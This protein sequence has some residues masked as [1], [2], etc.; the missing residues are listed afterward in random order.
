MTCIL[1]NLQEA[2]PLPPLSFYDAESF[3]VDQLG[4]D[5]TAGSKA[6]RAMKKNESPIRVREKEPEALKGIFWL[7]NQGDSSSV[8]SFAKTDE[9]GGVSPG[10]LQTGDIAYRIRVSGDQSWAFADNGPND[11]YNLAQLADLVYNFELLDGTLDAPT[12]F[13]IIPSLQ[14]P[15][16]C[17][18]LELKECFIKEGLLDFS[19]TLTHGAGLPDHPVYEESVV[20]RRDSTLFGNS[21]SYEAV[22]IIDGDGYRIEPAWSMWVSY[23]Q[24][25]EAGDTPGVNHYRRLAEKVKKEDRICVEGSAKSKSKGS[26]GLKGSRRRGA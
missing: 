12:K 6:K 9:G 25:M 4:K 7:M 8:I 1:L 2:L 5:K 14:I 23:Q 3:S 11:N 17:L 10:N 21:G 19:M 20:W 13:Q 15:F 24:S 22:Q 18:R 16:L 26:R